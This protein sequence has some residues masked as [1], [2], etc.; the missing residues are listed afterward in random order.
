MTGRKSWSVIFLSLACAA[1]PA[2]AQ[3]AL[4]QALFDAG[5]SA[6]SR[7]NLSE[8]EKQ[9]GAAL[10]NADADAR[11]VD[12][13]GRLALILDQE[14]KFQ[15]A[16]EQYERVFELDKKLHGQYSVEVGGDLNSLGLVCQHGGKFAEAEAFFKQAIAVF[17][18]NKKNLELAGVT[19]NLALLLQETARY[20]G[21]EPLLKQALALYEKS[22]NQL[23]LAGVLDRYAAFCLLE[24]RY[25][26]AEALYN[27]ALSVRQAVA[28]ASSPLVAD[29][30]CELGR[31]HMS[32]GDF[33]RAE[34]ELRRALGIVR[35]TSSDKGRAA[36]TAAALADCL[37]SQEKYAE[38]RVLYQEALDQLQSSSGTKNARVAEALRNLAQNYVDTGEYSRAES[39]LLKALATDE[40][41]Y[42]ALHPDLAVD[43]QTLG[44]VYL[45]QGKYDLAEPLYKK[46]LT[47]TET[48]LGATHP[49]TATSL[50]NLAWLYYNM[51]KYDLAEPLVVRALTIRQKQFGAKHPL[52]AQNLSIYAVILSAQGKYE[53]AEPLLLR[54]IAAEEEALGVDHP[55]ISANLKNLALIYISA[56]KNGE[57]EETLRKLLARDEKASG[58]DSAA[59][60][61]DL[62]ALSTVLKREKKTSEAVEC[63]SRSQ[64]IKARLPGALSASTKIKPMLTAP[65]K[66]AAADFGRPVRD[67]WALVV[68]ISNFKD[69][70]INLRYAAKDATDF[71]N[72]LVNEAHFQPD[73]V[74]LLTDAR[75]TRENIV[76]NLGEKWLRKLA[77]KDDLVCIYISSHGSAAKPEAGATN[78]VVPYEGNMENLVFSGI[79][80]QWLTAGLKDL[81]HCDRMVVLLDVCH[82]GAATGARAVEKGA[83][84]G[85]TDSAAVGGK[86]V[87]RETGVDPSL[88]TVGDGQVV[89][90]SSSASQVSWESQNYQNGVF[91]RRLIEGLKQRGDK[92]TIDEAFVY[93]KERVEEEVLRDRAQVQTPVMEKNWQGADLLLAAPPVAPGP[94]PGSPA[95]NLPPG[96]SNSV[97]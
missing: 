15:E 11:V 20:E 1:L 46:A 4:W 49:S 47:L 28:G 35:L 29:T 88:I 56:G 7:G 75:A 57:A 31:L 12:T 72:Y 50:N 94:G 3:N 10:K 67:K 86:G 55:D 83:G 63:L 81:V 51:G 53:E 93:M 16:K 36:D 38:A 80:M 42:G 89:L 25:F 95:K 22:D 62:E 77:K 26:E 19:T 40:E 87:G 23:A 9:L 52:V 61:S 58:K 37:R 97:K 34:S 69:S 92:T 27:R 76:S 14:G 18:K 71:R 90:A 78:F 66:N 79:P 13:A 85:S 44:L 8:A 84:D 73:H 70:A 32:Q 39:L 60:A 17:E 2:A 82:G 33:S 74:C 21:V 96:K 41:A 5:V 64:M 59:V 91:T 24:S 48:V 54:A 65:G 6:Q 43:L 45:D 68:G 30:L